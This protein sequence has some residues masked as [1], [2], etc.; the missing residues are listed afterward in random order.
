MSGCL[1]CRWPKRKRMRLPSS[2]PAPSPSTHPHLEHIGVLAQQVACEEAAV[3]A[4]HDRRAAA[5]RLARR[6]CRGQR[7]HAVRHVVCA[8]PARQ[9]RESSL[10]IPGGAAVVGADNA[11]AACR[12]E[13]VRHVPAGG[14]GRVGAAVRRDHGRERPGAGRR[15]ERDTLKRAARVAARRRHV[16]DLRS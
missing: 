13:H 1:P 10:P 5:V 12:K 8:D 6:N 4:P 7:C 14:H 15:E 2:L 11:V 3:A 16:H 9:R